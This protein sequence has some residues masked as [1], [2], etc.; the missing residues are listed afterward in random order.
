[1][2]FYHAFLVGRGLCIWH[3]VRPLLPSG[4]ARGRRVLYKDN[5]GQGKGLFGFPNP[6]WRR[7]FDGRY[8]SVSVYT[9]TNKQPWD[10]AKG[11]PSN[12]RSLYFA[13]ILLEGSTDGTAPVA[14]SEV[15]Y[16]K[17]LSIGNR[18]NNNYSIYVCYRLN[19]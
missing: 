13:L 6:V 9:H 4:L 10:A 12:P 17:C 7:G 11:P 19:C 16:L 15:V 14:N 8:L 5:Q 1:M 2:V 3:R 18:N